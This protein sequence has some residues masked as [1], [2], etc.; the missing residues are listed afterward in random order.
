M[1]TLTP[2]GDALTWD[3]IDGTGD[4]LFGLGETT[5]YIVVGSVLFEDHLYAVVLECP[6]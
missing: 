2:C 1:F 4:V 5:Y 6:F 3:V